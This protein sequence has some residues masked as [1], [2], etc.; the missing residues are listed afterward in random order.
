MRELNTMEFEGALREA[1]KGAAIARL[2]FRDTC[3][4]EVQFPDKDSK[5]TMPYLAMVKKGDRFPVTLSCE[6]IFA[7]DWYVLER[8]DET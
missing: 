1:K 2:A 8:S 5:N 7:S 6:S 4:V 3:H